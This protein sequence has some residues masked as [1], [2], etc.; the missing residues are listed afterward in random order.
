MKCFPRFF[1]SSSL[2]PYTSAFDPD[3]LIFPASFV[4]E[5]LIVEHTSFQFCPVSD[6]LRSM[7][8]LLCLGPL[9]Y[10]IDLQIYLRHQCHAVLVTTAWQCNLKLGIMIPPTLLFCLRLLCSFS[11]FY[12]S[13]RILGSFFLDL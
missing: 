2:K 3:I 11:V 7:R 9:F 4:E 1:F 6:C 8:L 5:Y 12:I 10:C 13:I